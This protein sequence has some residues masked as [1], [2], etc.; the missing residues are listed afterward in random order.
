[1]SK[2]KDKGENETEETKK[3]SSGDILAFGSVDLVMKL[4]LDK[5]DL[6]KYKVKWNELESLENLKFIRKHKHF[7]KRVELSSS[8]ENM[9]ILLHINKSSKKLVKIGYIGF[10][11]IK[12]KNEQVEFQDFV[13]SVINQNG[14]FLTSCDVCECKICIQ[15]LLVFEKKE[16][17]FVLSGTPE[18]EKKEEDIK[19]DDNE[20][21]K[22]HVEEKEEE[23]KEDKPEENDKDKKG[24]ESN[25]PLVNISDE[26]VE[27]GE[28]NYIYFNYNDYVNGEFS[29]KIK[30]DNLYEYFQTLKITTHS[31]IIVN[32]KKEDINKEQ[33]IRDLFSLTDIFIFYNKNK[34]YNILKQFKEEEDNYNANKGYM[35]YQKESKRRRRS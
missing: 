21:Q 2:G 4:N 8:N 29:S 35:Y 31:K 14:L 26:V 20:I 9:N 19:E 7:W 18:E 11:K 27:P 34:L 5:H 12:F 23:K 30:L 32:F 1:M 3:L 25:N 24:E 28:F 17:K 22:E 6:K 13:E 16:K 33:I 15:L 10:K